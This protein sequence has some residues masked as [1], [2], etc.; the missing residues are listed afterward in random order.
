VRWFLID[1]LL[2]CEPGRR[3]VA[4]KTFPMSDLM[5]LTHFD[6]NPVVPGVL[7]IEMIAQAA[8]K[9]LKIL[10]PERLTMLVS[11]KSAKF[12]KPV[13]P[14]DRCHITVD[15][16]TRDDYAT[17]SGIVEVDGVRVSQAELLVAFVPRLEIEPPERDVIIAA[18]MRRQGG[19]SEPLAVVTRA[20]AVV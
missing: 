1:Q 20:D 14:G 2:E 5:F 8:A 19:Q 4:V 10:R 7:H 15:I 3:A 18:W 17:E 11:V 16:T 13:L 12:F 9:S 6:A